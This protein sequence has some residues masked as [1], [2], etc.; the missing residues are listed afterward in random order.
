MHWAAPS[1][2]RSPNSSFWT[3]GS[4]EDERKV[5]SCLLLP[6]C[7]LCLLLSDDKQKLAFINAVYLKKETEKGEEQLQQEN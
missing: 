2:L 5:S 6:L 4:R 1:R 7:F 3:A